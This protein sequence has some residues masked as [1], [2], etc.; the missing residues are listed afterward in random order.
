MPVVP[1][2]RKEDSRGQ[3]FSPKEPPPKKVTAAEEPWILMSAAVMDAEGRL[4]EEDGG[5]TVKVGASEG[6]SNGT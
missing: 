4:T 5:R 3:G 1:Y 2:V 6:D